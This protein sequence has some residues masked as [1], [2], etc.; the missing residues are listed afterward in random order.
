[1]TLLREALSAGL[2]ALG[3]PSAMTRGRPWARQDVAEHGRRW[4]VLL[5]H[6]FAGS[7]AVWGP[8]AQALRTA[9]FGY[10]VRLSYNSFTTDAAHVVRLVREQVDVALETTDADGVHLIGHSLGGLLL[11]HALD[12]HTFAGSATV[13]TIATPHAGIR[14]ARWIPGSCAR[15]MLPAP[16]APRAASPQHRG[17]RSIAFWSDGDWVVRPSSARL[18]EGTL[19]VTNVHVPG[20]GHL[21]ICRDPG[22]ITRL[23]RELLDSEQRLPAASA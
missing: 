10:V 12:P 9:G 13:V 15:L 19:P 7:D 21:T 18:E 11:R 23:V 1:V 3:L 2:L 22:L 6:G 4:P 5:L 17:I 16:Q 14:L 20:C 8:L